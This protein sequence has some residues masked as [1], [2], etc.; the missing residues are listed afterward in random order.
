[1]HDLQF[2]LHAIVEFFLLKIGYFLIYKKHIRKKKEKDKKNGYI[3]YYQVIKIIFIL[4][5]F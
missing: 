1:M 2:N 3:Y 5:Y 4:F